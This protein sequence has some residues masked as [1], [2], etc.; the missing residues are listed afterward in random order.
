MFSHLIDVNILDIIWQGKLQVC[1][2]GIK[3]VTLIYTPFERTLDLVIFPFFPICEYMIFKV[4][5]EKH[6]H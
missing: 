4:S 6:C 3:Y 2:A 1:D 5:F